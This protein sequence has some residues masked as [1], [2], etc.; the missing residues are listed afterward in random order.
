[1][2]RRK[3]SDHAMGELM[4]QSLGCRVVILNASSEG[5]HVWPKRPPPPEIGAFLQAHHDQLRALLDRP[6][7]LGLCWEDTVV[8]GEREEFVAFKLPFPWHAHQPTWN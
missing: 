5:F 6:V 1:M 4:L 2:K 7:L 3:P 8:E